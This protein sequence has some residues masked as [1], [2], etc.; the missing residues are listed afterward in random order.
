MKGKSYYLAPAY[1]VL[2]AGGAVLLEIVLMKKRLIWLKYAIPSLLLL[3]SIIVSPVW[4]PVLPVEKAKESGIMNYRYDYR[5]MV[6]WTELVESVSEV[7][8]TL[9]DE[10]K[11]KTEII[12]GNYGEAGSI[13]HYGEKYGLPEASSG[14]SSYYYWGPVNPEASTVIFVGYPD[15]YLNRYFSDVKVMGT[16]TNR[17]EID[18]EE[19]GQ[20]ITL[21][22]KPIKPLSELWEEFKH[23]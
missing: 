9:P 6:G 22:R 12:T 14:I 2:F 17:Y 8:R 21:C 11:K 7:Y 10:E 19:Q 5:E 16:I 20:L 23:Y 13:N 15:D 4:L 1:P 18:N 3:T